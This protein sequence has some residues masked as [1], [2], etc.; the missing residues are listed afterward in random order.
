M[1]PLSIP[2]PPTLPTQLT[3]PT[4]TAKVAVIIQAIII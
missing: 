2:T 1:Q 4:A 3:Q